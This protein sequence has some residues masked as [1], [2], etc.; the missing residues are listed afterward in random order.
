MFRRGLQLWAAGW[1]LRLA[2]LAVLALIVV[3]T[4]TGLSAPFFIAVVVVG[5]LGWFGHR[6]FQDFWANLD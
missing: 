3:Y 1:A 2:L 5:V 6:M 4:V